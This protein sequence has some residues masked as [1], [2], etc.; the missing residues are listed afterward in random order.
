MPNEFSTK[1]LSVDE[2]YAS[3][4]TERGLAYDRI[5][6]KIGS[7][8]RD[9]SPAGVARMKRLNESVM[10]IRA[11][12][13]SAVHSNAIMSELSLAYVNDDYI[14]ERLMPA[15]EVSK[16]SDEYAVFPKRDRLGYPDDELS[17]RSKPNEITESRST[18][19]YSVKDYGFSGYVSQDTID[20]QDGAFDEMADLVASV[21]EGVAF[22]REKRI[23][24]ILTTSGNFSGNTTA[25]S[26]QSKW[27]AGGG[28]P[29]K[30]IQDSK[31]ALWN[32]GGQT[33]LLG[34]CSLDVANTLARHPAL[35]D[36]FKAQTPGLATMKMIANYLG[37][38]DILVG[39]ARQ[40]TANDGQSASYSRIWGDHFGIVRVMR[41]PS[42]RTAAF[43]ATFRM[44][45]D[46]VATQWYDPSV[47]KKGGYYAK[48]GTSEDHKIIAADT[49]Y[50]LTSVI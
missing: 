19:N 48:V 42:K 27:S 23:A 29:I 7:W 30:N 25:L 5:V 33:D 36:L 46:P 39:A 6:Q 13:P 44:K 10:A 41:R 12:G 17:T 24:T 9:K 21:A 2:I 47:G 37:L 43:G 40:D 31:A 38:S 4:R 22:K 15:V 35:R 28:D 26:G 1:L 32:G 16:R 14:G 11:V 8:S 3:Q 34:Y 50:L 18:D 49:G 20:N 45:G